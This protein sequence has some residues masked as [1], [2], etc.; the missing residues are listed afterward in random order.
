MNGLVSLTDEILT[1]IYENFSEEWGKYQNFFSH[2][3]SSD[4]FENKERKLQQMCLFKSME[5]Y[6]TWKES[7]S[8]HKVMLQY[9][10]I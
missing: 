3:N 5:N 7:E 6:G 9:D 1:R 10:H 4:N 2:W 8:S